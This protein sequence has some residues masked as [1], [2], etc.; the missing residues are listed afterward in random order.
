MDHNTDATFIK[1]TRP[2]LER[3]IRRAREVRPHV[4]RVS[5]RVYEVSG[6]KP[7][8]AYRVELHRAGG[9]NLGRCSCAASG[10]CYHLASASALHIAIQ[11]ARKGVA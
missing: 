9:A 5:E 10:T 1:L 2:V 4:R 8:T 7:G 11:T 3:A 6:S